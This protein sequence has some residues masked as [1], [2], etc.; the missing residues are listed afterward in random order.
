V[1]K[2]ATMN[3]LLLKIK[4][5]CLLIALAFILNCNGKIQETQ[6]SQTVKP[7][8]VLKLHSG[9]Q[10]KASRNGKMDLPYGQSSVYVLEYETDIGAKDI[11]TLR[12]EADEIWE[13]IQL[14]AEKSQLN[15]AVIRVANYEGSGVLHCK[16]YG[17]GYSKQDKGNWDLKEDANDCRVSET[18]SKND[19]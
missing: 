18:N 6:N 5:G 9:K 4:I 12:K 1:V 3:H 15:E 16:G 8:Q 7:S 11:E 14:E 10:I 17:F 13:T 19:L 2:I